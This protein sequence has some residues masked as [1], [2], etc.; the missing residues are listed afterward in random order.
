[1]AYD[2]ASDRLPISPKPAEAVAAMLGG[3]LEPRLLQQVLRGLDS[4]ARTTLRQDYRLA[5]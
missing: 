3:G 4:H 1:M 2:K 5:S